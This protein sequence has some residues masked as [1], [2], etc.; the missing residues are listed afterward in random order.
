MNIDLR[1]KSHFNRLAADICL[2]NNYYAPSVHCSYYS[3]VQYMLYILFEK[4]K[5]TETQFDQEMI[6]LRTG[7]HGCAIKLI[8]F[9][10]IKRNRSDYKTFQA[11][12]PALKKL[13]EE[14]DYKPKP[15]PQ[16]EGQTALA[17]SDSIKNV[18]QKN[19]R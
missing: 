7:T 6:N 16:H 18:L 12:I 9:D 11:L 15:T 10:L 14:A 4:L 5:M 1:D 17:T 13:R 3:C 8:G 2:K 19:Y